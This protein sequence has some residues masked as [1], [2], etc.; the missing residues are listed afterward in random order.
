MTTTDSTSDGPRAVGILADPQ[1]TLDLL[2][3]PVADRSDPFTA[4]R[5]AVTGV[6]PKSYSGAV[7]GTGPTG[8][9][10]AVLYLHLT[11]DDLA[12]HV[13][14]GTGTVVVERIG[15]TSLEL[16]ETWL[17][18][19]TFTVRPVLDLTNHGGTGIEHRRSGPDGPTAAA[20]RPAGPS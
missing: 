19:R 9:G 14:A 6:G 5:E 4:A 18:G 3:R 20:H 11:P 7:D 10:A 15:A 8:G 17:A 2:A 13:E 12:E 16:V 1:H